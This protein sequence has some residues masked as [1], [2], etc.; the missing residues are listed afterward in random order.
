MFRCPRDRQWPGR[1]CRGLAKRSA[2]WCERSAPEHLRPTPSLGRWFVAEQ[3]TRRRS[4]RILA[5]GGNPSP[6]GRSHRGHQRC[7]IGG[8]R[9]RQ[10]GSVPRLSPCA[11]CQGWA[12]IARMRAC[13]R[14]LSGQSG[15]GMPGS[16]AS[17]GWVMKNT[18]GIG[19]PRARPA[20]LLSVS[21][22]RSY[23]LM[24][25]SA[26]S[27]PSFAAAQAAEAAA[28][29][30]AE[31]RARGIDPLALTTIRCHGSPAS[32]FCQDS[33]LSPSSRPGVIP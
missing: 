18:V 23:R 10:R 28:R 33:R 22:Y 5:L 32:L 7:C 1:H 12:A 4:L 27:L 31:S 8:A 25:L 29:E 9:A 21:A 16:I 6:I 11:R 17:S 30:A 3:R 20:R 15:T 2:R 13:P 14:S 24:A 19:D 26:F